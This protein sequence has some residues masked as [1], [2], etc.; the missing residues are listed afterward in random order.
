MGWAYG[1]L[2]RE[3]AIQLMQRSL[4]AYQRAGNLVMQEGVLSTLGVV[5]QWAGRWDE[6]SSYYERSRDEASKI[7]NTVG[8]ALARV[9]VAE[10]LIDRGEWAEAEVL[11]LETLPLWKSSQY[12]YY[13]GGCLWFLGRVSLCLGRFE[14]ALNRLEEAKSNFLHV[15]AEE[16]VP[17]IDAR[18]AECRVAMGNVDV[19]LELA[20]G[21]LR[22]AAESNGV[23]RVVSLLE[24]VHGARTFEAGRSVGRA[25]R[26]GGKSCRGAEA[27]RPVRSHTDA[28]F[29]DRDRSP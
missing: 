25:R 14:E 6:A 11:L 12:R 28:T 9:N 26:A 17:A 24:R 1:E 3:G 22:R 4:E 23:A 15:G 13:L 19:A 20:E 10:I 27:A 29:A 2:G 18:I 16:Q 21:L 5:C 8:A 7:G